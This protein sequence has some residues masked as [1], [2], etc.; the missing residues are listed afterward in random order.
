MKIIQTLWTKPGLD[1][2]WIDKQFHFFSWA[3]S[4]LQLRK[5]YNDVEL[6]T[7]QLGKHL[8]I[9]I[10]KL[11]Y[12]K[13]HLTLDDFNYSSKLW[14]APKLLSYS[15]QDE[16]F[17]H[18]DGDIFIF[19]PFNKKRLDHGLVYQ[20]KEIE[21]GSNEFYKKIFLEVLALS[22]DKSELPKWIQNASLN[23]I[24]ALN[25]G[26]LGGNNTAYFKK[27]GEL[28]FDFFDNHSALINN[29][30]N[31]SYATF[32]AEQV[33]ASILLKE[34]EIDH[35]G[36]FTTNYVVG[37]LEVFENNNKEERLQNVDVHALWSS[38]NPTP[39]TYFSL[40]HFGISPFGRQYVH[41]LGANKKAVF[42]CSLAAKRLLIDYPEYY[43]R[44]K[45]YFTHE[46]AKNKRQSNVLQPAFADVQIEEDNK[47]NTL[48]H[49]VNNL[50]CRKIFDRTIFLYETL[51]GQH[52]KTYNN[53]EFF[54]NDFDRVLQEL[55]GIDRVRIEDVFNLEKTR[56]YL[57]IDSPDDEYLEYLENIAA[58]SIKKI[59]DISQP[60]INSFR[61][62]V[63]EFS[64]VISTKWN[65][66]DHRSF[67]KESVP[68]CAK[69]TLILI[70]VTTKSMIELEL[71]K[72]N[73]IV[74]YAFST[75]TTYSK[76]VDKA[77]EIV[78]LQNLEDFQI[79]FFQ[80]VV[81]LITAGVLLIK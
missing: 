28:A 69:E 72:F 16:P 5:F 40:D 26:V 71:T 81:Y 63:N 29:M 56:Y 62:E 44:I 64:R 65:W 27:L 21:S 48:K 58:E 79:H 14:S 6:Y 76:A 53:I 7:D 73:E 11:P 74:L 60:D 13:V 51:T 45:E 39:F 47:F 25:A 3:L 17:L 46:G 10:F 43:Y 57:A 67:K 37:P 36:L 32:I 50:S 55:E 35:M 23:N 33:L 19:S 42:S 66:V 80:C 41:L 2:G 68:A 77:L 61:F 49:K 15:L 52:L 34:Q 31:P 20:N 1:A 75:E 18:V 78:E 30:R 22:E 4:C 24:E 59:Y 54:I 9:D 38:D 70:D 12:T 8:L